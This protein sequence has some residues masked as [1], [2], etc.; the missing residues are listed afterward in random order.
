MNE[1]LERLARLNGIELAYRDIWGKEHAAST[2]TLVSLLRAM[3]ID[4]TDDAR[5]DTA[6]A[7]VDEQ[8][9]NRVLPPVLVHYE[10]SGPW[11]LRLNLTLALDAEALQWTIDDE[12]GDQQGGSF[13]PRELRELE[14]GALDGTAFVARELV[15]EVQLR[16][17][18][19]Q[20]SLRKDG[21]LRSTCRLIVAP[22]KCYL[23]RALEGDGRVWG[24]V[25]HVYTLRSERNWGIG[26]FSDLAALVEL[27]G[28]HGAGIVGVNPL[29]ALFPHNPE[30]V[31]P[32]SPSNRRFL[33]TLYLDVEAIEDFR[34]D[35]A[36]REAVRS[37]DFQRRLQSLRATEQVDYPGVAAAKFQILELLF[38]HF[39]TEHL[40]RN[41]DRARQF[42]EWRALRGEELH[43]H[44]LFEALQEHF[45]GLDSSVWGWPVWP[46]AFRRPQ[47]SEVAQFAGEHGDRVTFYEYLQ[48]QAD[49]QLGAVGRR[50]Y[51]RGLGV[52]LYADLAVSVDR[53]GAEAWLH[54]DLY[55]L[56]ASVGA[57]ADEFNQHGQN[58]GLPPLNPSR[59]WE[60]AYAPF[61]AMLRANMRHAGALRIDHVMA[62]MRL[63]WIHEGTAAT[64]GA[65]VQYRFDDL[66]GIVALESVRNRCVVIGEDLGT[67]PEEVRAKLATV[68]VLSY[69]LL[70]FERHQD[71]EFVPPA[72][73]PQHSLVAA[74]TH[75]LPTLAGW[76]EGRDLMLRESMGQ[77]ANR[78]AR[79]EQVVVRAQDRA[80]LLLAL[81]RDG[82]LPPGV[83]VNPVSVPKMTP[84][85]CA[86]LHQRLASSPARI[87]VAQLEDVIGAVD[88]LN[89]PGTTDQ[90][91][92]W[93]RKLAL[94][95]ERWP[96][97]T[98][99]INMVRGFEH[100]RGS[101]RTAAVRREAI[102]A[103]IPRATYRVQLNRDFRF[104]A[105]RALV[106]YLAQLGI[107]HLYCSPFL[108]A[109][110]GSRHGYDIVD[111]NQFNPEIGSRHEFEELAGALK[112]HGMGMLI[113]VVPNHMGVLG[114]DNGWWIDVL[115][116]GR[117][118]MYAE[119][120]DIDWRDADP[121]LAMRV[122]L[123]ILGDHY[124]VVLERGELRL[125]FEPQSGSFSLRYHE[126]LLPIDP[127]LYP[128]VLSRAAGLL[129][130]AA[131]EAETAD[132]FSSVLAAF[133]HLPSR[134]STDAALRSERHRDKEVHKVNLARLARAHPSIATAIEQAVNSFNGDP[135]ERASFDELDALI[136]SQVYRLAYWRVAADEINYRRFFDINELAALRMEN[137][138]V[139][140]ATHRL[141]LDLATRGQVD[142]F[143]IDHPDGL[144]DPA[145]YFRRLQERYAQLCGAPGAATS[146]EGER[147]ARP[148]YV[149]AEKIVAA[150]EQLPSDWA[151]HGTTGYRFA[152]VV[153]G[154]F[155]DTAAKSRLDRAWRAFVGAEAVDFDDIARDCRR[156]VMATSL[157][158]EMSVLAAA[159]L[160]LARADR[161]TRDFTL[162]ALR[163]A[164]TEVVANFPV[165]R[166][167]IVDGPSAQDHRYI[168][169]AV[170]RAR[171]HSP[172]ADASTFSFIHSVL[173]GRVPPGGSDA[174]QAGY[175]SFARRLQQFTAPVMAKGVEDT[176]FYRHQRLVAVNEV[177]GD[178]DTV[179]V[180]VSAFHG[181][182][183][184]RV[185]RWPH[186]MLATSTHDTKRSEDAR[187]RLDVISEMPAVWRL[188]VRRWSR[189]NRRHR[190]EVEDMPAPARNDEYLLY[191]SLVGTLPVDLD[192]SGLASYRKRIE[193]YMLKATREA[194]E[195]TSWITPNEAYE[196]ALS[197][198]V[199][200][201]LGKLAGNQ[202]LDDLRATTS[203]FAWFGALNSI[204]MT[205]IKLTSPGVPDFFQGEE[206]IE[207]SL[208]D[209]D[210]RRAVDYDA[211]R[212]A[213][214]GLLRFAE[215]AEHSARVRSM[216]ASAAD[217]RAKLWT[218]WRLLQLRR[219]HPDLF[220]LGDYTAMNVTGTRARHT[221][222]YARRHEGQLILVVSGRLFATLGP[223]TGESPIGEAWDGTFVDASI[224]PAHCRLRDALSGTSFDVDPQTA[225]P[226]AKLLAHF[227]VAVLH[228][229]LPGLM[230]NGR[231]ARG[232]P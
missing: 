119:F 142:G 217:G 3:G 38:A 69:R 149:V 220:E 184:D 7:A 91:P 172:A 129:S 156:L 191:Q 40:Q 70:Y 134:D 227:P 121:V 114:G 30:H 152:N 136:E 27:W 170:A 120:F 155:I 22:R 208:V 194:K 201:L 11:T 95:L 102:N 104:S 109:R 143:R 46:A 81:E 80:R 58:W 49:L 98:R 50:S 87:V 141:V 10:D 20:V 31:S 14:R 72:A 90:Y 131:L 161:R 45:H 53:A 76:W 168:D 163:Q 62:L 171:R 123:P 225:L 126:H 17:G 115:E 12:H 74:S 196:A 154:L 198:F 159:L 218:I 153:N 197:Q 63:Y 55:C 189:L 96:G 176:A 16:T 47:S 214:D 97:D 101:S 185:Q 9:W 83:T 43:G 54:Q 164:L 179:G 186:T 2:G 5:L 18:Y 71:G 166:T 108:R 187:A 183:R 68:G 144:H 118:S 207:L 150:H 26:D 61:I 34:Q 59:L 60:A 21:V 66:L 92:N 167:Y 173:L 110:A 177:G 188:S 125:E 135:R 94:S 181:A 222:A 195:H 42:N 215:A 84:E 146:A 202:F 100:E 165:Y 28:L 51:E 228:G 145:G 29:H 56:D 151:V 111:H 85:L 112:Q 200:A 15:L 182:C 137:A 73:F 88:Q 138:D 124:G 105:A 169:W 221:L 219:E 132:A 213:L 199:G 8:R 192:E 205:A 127:V 223:A 212:R 157:A 1:R 19:H 106:P 6:I 158:G 113:D 140:D 210:S 178:P 32:Y 57:P 25:A 107:S 162:N 204:A 65:Y 67:V 174:L 64:D 209:P 206:M 224:L 79:D 175:L 99:F 41:S 232:P 103:V 130:H 86:V 77:F 147:P 39:R 203:T 193:S 24:A 89:L 226:L 75:D 33:N 116:N 128:R 229:E 78:Q 35:E 211:R 44:C 148:L 160:R 133:G 4:A 117:A 230:P 37:A 231:A 93:C 180:T 139:F 13:V 48:W 82:L 23:P 52:G 122:L 190:R 36:A 216:L